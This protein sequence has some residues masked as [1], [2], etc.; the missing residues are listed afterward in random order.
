VAD[1]LA[2]P[3]RLGVVLVVCAPSGAGKSTLVKRL[4]S[5]FPNLRFSVSCTTRPARPGEV[6]GRD[7]RFLD[8]A[9][10]E[11]LRAEGHF[12]EWAEVHG[13]LYGTPRRPVEEALAGGRDV[14]FD[15][16]VQG[17]RQ[18][19]TSFPEGIFV[20][21]LPPSLAELARRLKGRGTDATEVVARR[22]DNARRE[23]AAAPEFG[24]WVVNDDLNAAYDELRA[25]YLAGRSRPGCRPGLLDAVRAKAEA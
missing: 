23:L 22:L 6:D 20:F 11:S 25:V 24:F 16:D 1:R 8:R 4:L 19:R 21:V 10:F 14:L 5:E 7:Y 3:G 9:A 13:N 17:A 12:A 2:D 15:I 18:L